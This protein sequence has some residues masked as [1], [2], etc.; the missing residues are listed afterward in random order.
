M[1]SKWDARY[2]NATTMPQINDFLKRFFH[3]AKKGVALDIAAGMGQNALFLAEHGFEV[4]AVDISA[5]G[6]QNIQ[7]IENIHCYVTDIQKFAFPKNLYTVI[8]NLNF[9]DR[10]IFQDIIISLQKG[11]LLFFQSFTQKSDMNPLFCVEKNELLQQ[12][13]DLEVL[14]Y[15]LF[16]DEKRVFMLARKS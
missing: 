3:K 10:S 2:K 11:G 7:G 1:K 12:F 5:I 15:E 16:D 8:L 13:S 14:Y 9:L 4:D 6:L